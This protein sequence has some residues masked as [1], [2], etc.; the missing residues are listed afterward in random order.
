MSR[1]SKR[2]SAPAPQAG[3]PLG[4]PGGQAVV[5]PPIPS[6]FGFGSWCPPNILP[7]PTTSSPAYCR[8]GLQQM[9]SSSTQVPW[10]TPPGVG[11]PSAQDQDVQAWGVDLHPPSGF[12]NLLNKNAS[13]PTQDV[14]NGS[15]S[16]PINIYDDTDYSKEDLILVG[17]WLNNSKDPIQSNY[18]KNDQYWKD[19]AVAYNR[20]VP[21]NRARQ[22]KHIKDRFARIK[23]KVTWFCESWKEANTLWASGESDADL[24]NKALKLYEDEHKKEGPFMF[25]HCWDVLRNE[26][27]W[28]A[29]VERLE[30]LEPDKRKFEE[31]I[32]EQFSLEHATD[33]RPIGGKK[34]KEQRKRKK[35]DE[36]CIIDLEGELIAFVEAQNKANE[37]RKEMLETQKRVSSEKLEAQK[38]A[39]LAAKE[40]KE[41]GMLEAYRELL[42]QDTTGMAEDVRSEHVLALKCLREKNFGN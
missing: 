12:V 38:L 18:K 13:N 7:Q 41:A 24:M 6:M 9:G 4:G 8:T 19:V 16:Q 40:N 10:W 31:D 5:P 17:A 37:S 22:V 3:P 2:T 28:D 14:N 29:Y 1:Q 20:A 26:P 36:A 30:D 11:A 23:K 34:A 39:Y 32:G 25:K 27:K 15:S 35:K 33:E 21:K 42:K